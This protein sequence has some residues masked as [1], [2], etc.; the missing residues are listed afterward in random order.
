MT[1]LS[2]RPDIDYPLWHALKQ[3][4][5]DYGKTCDASLRAKTLRKFG[6]NRNVGTSAATIMDLPTGQTQ[7]TLPST[8]V[9]VVASST[10]A[11][12]TQDIT[13]LEGHESQNSDTTLAFQASTTRVA[14]TG[15]TSVDTG[16]DWAR[17]TN[18]RLASPAVGTVYI[19]EGGATTNGVPD[20]LTTVHAII[21]PGELQTQKASTSISSN[22][23]WV[24]T[25]ASI[26]VLEKTG[27]FIEA[28]VEIQPF[29]NGQD[30]FPLTESFH[31]T[32]TSSTASMI[33][34]GDAPLIVPSNYDVR[35]RAVANAT[36]IDVVAGISGFLLVV[37]KDA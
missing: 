32:Y 37:L 14:L 5:A 13:L 8:N 33:G 36:G 31:T 27:G 10:S 23:F 35:I 2:Q 28:R 6:R 19:H 25:R 7:E 4:E 12:D 34:A 30:W 21:Q 18:V 26:G 22:D 20:D 24:I 9:S 16:F 3:I 15:Q 1:D 17:V 29:N 11:S